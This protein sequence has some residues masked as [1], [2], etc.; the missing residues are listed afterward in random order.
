MK[1]DAA[2]V[3]GGMAGLTAAAYLVR[4]GLSV[5]LFEKDLEVGGLVRTFNRGGF[6]FDGGIRAV[7]SSDIVL[8]MLAQ[9]G[10]DVD[11]IPSP[12]SIGLGRD[13]VRL[14]S[15][16]SLGQYRDLLY[17]KFPDRKADIRE[18]IHEILKV[19]DYMDVLYGIDNPLFLEFSKGSAETLRGLV[20]WLFK[21]L[22][23]M[24]KIARLRKPVDEYVAGFTQDRALV[25]MVAQHFFQKTPTYFALSYFSLYLDYRYPRGG[26]GALPRRLAQYIAER[27]GDIRVGTEIQ[28]VDP[29]KRRITDKSG[30]EYGYGNL[31]WAADAASLVRAMESNPDKASMGGKL[32][33]SIDKRAKSL[34]GMRG[35]DSI[36]SIFLSSS[37]PPDYF[38][39]ITSPHLFH[40][41]SLRGLSTNPL[42]SVRPHP[43]EKQ[44]EAPASRAA[45]KFI[46]DKNKL[47]HWVGTF[48]DLTTYEIS[49]PSLRD[50][51][52]SPPGKT[53][54]IVSTLFDRDLTEHIE[55]LGWYE[56]LKEYA[57]RKAT[58]IL[59][60]TI[61]P[62]LSA[63][64]QDTSVATPLTL[65]RM[66]GNLDGAITGWAFTN[67][68]IPAET[69]LMRIAKAVETP[70]PGIFQ[71]GQWSFSPAGLPISILTGKLAADRIAKAR[72]VKP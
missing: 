3:G 69:K 68:S 45:A 22:A 41:P 39:N 50:P 57:A 46:K 56:E 2:V 21:Y 43:G 48:L 60:E 12:V 14:G 28:R 9:L 52:L 40:T 5:I 53:G 58:S 66:T 4:S 24:P 27:G 8:P 64:V 16:D 59:D 25:D 7:E 49:I 62:G 34:E 23:T 26:T 67:P 10:I 30:K 37:L 35:S 32:K 31:V 17:R 42:S 36:L 71:A 44:G 19:M 70:I 61:F 18:I 15:R 1:Y 11:F 54:I 65:E 13:I 47:F 72:K 33:E 38:A 29:G 63:S 20:P 6:V 51:A 55:S